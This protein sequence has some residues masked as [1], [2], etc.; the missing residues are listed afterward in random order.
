MTAHSLE[1]FLLN[2]ATAIVVQD[3]E[4]RLHVLGALLGKATHVEELL[5]AEGVWC[6]W[7][8]ESRVR[9]STS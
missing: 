4:N 6:W 8:I 7:G 3:R 1:L 9:N 5:G 2:E